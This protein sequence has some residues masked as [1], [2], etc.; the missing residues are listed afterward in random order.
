MN[1]RV[2]LRGT[3]I[4]TLIVA[5]ALSRL[6]PH[7]P[8]FT[9]VGALALFA[10]TYLADKRLAFVIPLAALALSDAILGFHLLLP[11]V[12][13][14]FAL[15]VC[16][17]FGLRKRVQLAGLATR[18]LAASVLFFVVTNFGVWELGTMYPHSIPGLISCYVAAIPFFRNTLLGDAS[19]T[20]LLFGS[21]A[22]AERV[23]PALRESAE[24]GSPA[25]SVHE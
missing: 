22:F 10:G 11:L 24:V 13:G 12:Y 17:G 3:T 5:A 4:V 7:P 8:N 21:F 19:F 23:I 18:V 20:A 14:C 6:L 15:T 2:T 1:G 16:L 25:T 9:P